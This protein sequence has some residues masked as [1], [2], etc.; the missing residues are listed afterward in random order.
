MISA[1]QVPA[2]Q[3]IW[4]RL[5]VCAASFFCAR[6]ASLA[7]CSCTV[8]ITGIATSWHR[9]TRSL[10]A[11]TLVESRFVSTPEM[12]SVPFSCRNPFCMSMTS[13]AALFKSIPSKAVSRLAMSTLL[14]V[15]TERARVAGFPLRAGYAR[16]LRRRHC[17]SCC[18]V[19]THTIFAPH[20]PNRPGRIVH[21]HASRRGAPIGC[22]PRVAVEVGGRRHVAKRVVHSGR[23]WKLRQNLAQSPDVDKD[24]IAALHRGKDDR[25]GQW[26]GR[27][28]LDLLRVERREVVIQLAVPENDVGAEHSLD[29]I[30]HE[31][32][33]ADIEELPG[34]RDAGVV[35][36][37]IMDAGQHFL[38]ARAL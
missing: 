33:L 36:E 18:K 28:P 5:A 34:L 24:Q 25:A 37:R 32:A 29:E 13:R 23:F 27:P 10:T 20:E 11:G 19:V 17:K 1:S 6:L 7:K 30:E 15:R 2:R 12:P 35:P 21:Q 3:E 8:Q 31:L 38:P 9:S 4:R 22:K 16:P 14:F 26:I